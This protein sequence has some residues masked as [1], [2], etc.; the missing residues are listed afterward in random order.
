MLGSNIGTTTTALIASLASDA[1]GL[2]NAVQIA[3]VHLFFNVIGI[4]IWYPIPFMRVP[5][6]LCKILGNITAEY[7][8][9]AIVIIINII[10]DKWP[11]IL[12]G[13]LKDFSFLPEFMR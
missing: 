2:E 6:V 11:S 12:P 8:W 13:F 4:C 1:R 10:Q 7:R 9:L 3:L 5:I